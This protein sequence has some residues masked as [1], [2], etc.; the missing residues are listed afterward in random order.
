M[1]E[2]AVQ[3]RYD[4]PALAGHAMNVDHLGPALLAMMVV[5]R[6]AAVVVNGGRTSVNVFVKSD[7]EHGCFQ[8]NF[9]V[10]QTL[11]DAAAPLLKEPRLATA[12]EILEWLGFV[13]GDAVTVGGL[14]AY[15][16]KRRA[17]KIESVRNV[18]SNNVELRFEGDSNTV[19]I[20]HNVY[21]MSEN[22]KIIKGIKRIVS[23]TELD[24]VDVVEFSEGPDSGKREVITKEE[25][26]YILDT[27]LPESGIE[28]QIIEARLRIYSPVFD[29]SAEKWRFKFGRQTITADIS[30]TSIAADAFARGHINIGDSWKVRLEIVERRTQAGNFVNDYR[31]LEVVG[32]D[33]GPMQEAMELLPPR[34]TSGDEP[35]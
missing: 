16:R 13:V 22:A 4:G 31:V 1:T 34:P 2:Q 30:G 8:I 6:E 28:P 11:L 18:D 35:A 33:P 15:L 5:C 23:P 12:K 27:D 17:R 14:I 10:I 32:F 26:R 3:L 7:F 19:V 9:E 24:G 29:V 20:N 25:A 21:H